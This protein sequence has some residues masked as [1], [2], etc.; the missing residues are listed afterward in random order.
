MPGPESCWPWVEDVEEVVEL[1]RDRLGLREGDGCAVGQV[2]HSG[3]A[4]AQGLSHPAQGPRVVGVR[5]QQLKQGAQCSALL[6]L[7]MERNGA[8][9]QS[10][11]GIKTCLMTETL[12]LNGG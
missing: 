2:L 7:R 12:R 9:K 6:I 10:Q 11:Y 4:S 5:Q 1:D 3:Q 8:V